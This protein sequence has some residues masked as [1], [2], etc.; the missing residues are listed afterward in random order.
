MIVGHGDDL[1]RYCGRIRANFSSNIY[2]P[3]DNTALKAHLSEYISLI[4]AYPEPQP[5]SLESSLARRLGV[6]VTNVMVC[7]GATDAI[8][9]IA[10]HLQPQSVAIVLEPTFSEYADALSA[11]GLDPLHAFDLSAAIEMADWVRGQRQ[12]DCSIWLC[13]PNNPNG[14]VWDLRDL[15]AWVTRRP[16]I[17]FVVDQS[18]DSFTLC[19]TLMPSA[20]LERDNLLILRSMT[21]QYKLPGL[22]LGYVCAS[23]N[24]IEL[25]RQGRMPWAVNALAIEAGLFLSEKPSQ[26]DSFDLEKL[27]QSATW[28]RSMLLDLGLEIEPTDT[29][30]MLCR[31]PDRLRL[32]S[33]Q[34]KQLL[35]E[36][37]GLLVRDASN[38]YGLSNRHIRIAAQSESDNESLVRAISEIVSSFKS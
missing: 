31:L 22:R 13:N 1:Y 16:D 10:H 21:K 37:Y 12:S 14:R 9:T 35:V 5:F 8:Y 11:V 38:F 36:D 20:V 34:F 3:T 2:A 6:G 19:P 23:E 26:E 4:D 18:Y 30:F 27:L 17:L 24:K 15:S 7:A 25:L 29:H 33:K 32:D 28:L